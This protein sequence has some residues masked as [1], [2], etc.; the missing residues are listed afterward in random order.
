MKE[1]EIALGNIAMMRKE[2]NMSIVKKHKL[3]IREH[4]LTCQRWLDSLELISSK[5]CG[6]ERCR[7]CEIFRDKF[8]KDLEQAIKLYEE[9]GI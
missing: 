5:H 1:A 2:R 6:C 7:S 8:E 4:K 9:K 3:F